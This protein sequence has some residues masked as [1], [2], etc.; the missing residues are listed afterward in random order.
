MEAARDLR[1]RRRAVHLS[2][3]RS[4]TRIAPVALA[5]WGAA[6]THEVKPEPPKAPTPVIEAYS[7]PTAVTSI[8]AIGGAVFVGTSLGIDRWEVATGKHHRLGA[9][10]GVAGTAVR[11]LALGRAGTLWFATDAGVGWFG[12]EGNKATMVAAPPQPPAAPGTRLRARAAA[13]RGGGRGPG[14]PR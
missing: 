6:C 14:A 9:L 3:I 13:Q 5:F 7:E 1:Y 2:R 10:D 4:L 8:V 12:I 11:A